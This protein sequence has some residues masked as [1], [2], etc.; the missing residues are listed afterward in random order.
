LGGFFDDSL[1]N[2]TPHWFR[3]SPMP[4]REQIF[5]TTSFDEAL[6]P[7]EE[8]IRQIAAETP[9]GNSQIAGCLTAVHN[10]WVFGICNHFVFPDFIV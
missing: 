3:V 2:F 9:I 10:L 5:C 6:S 8:A 7:R 1:I 4:C